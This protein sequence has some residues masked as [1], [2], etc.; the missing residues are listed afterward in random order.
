[1]DVMKDFGN[2]KIAASEG[3]T[4]PPIPPGRELISHVFPGDDTA[5]RTA[6]SRRRR[7]WATL[8]ALV[9]AGATA[10]YVFASEGSPDRRSA[11]VETP[12]TLKIQQGRK[13]PRETGSPTISSPRQWVEPPQD[14]APYSAKSLATAALAIEGADPFGGIRP[15]A[16]NVPVPYGAVDLTRL[17]ARGDHLLGLGDVASA[18]LVYRIAALGGSAAAAA[19]MGSTYDPKYLELAGAQG[20]EAKPAEAIKWYEK[21]FVM[22]EP[23]AE[24]RLRELLDSLESGRAIG[25]A[26][27]VPDY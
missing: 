27:I 5:Q 15:Q 24:A 16:R 20:I 7:R 3:P 4:D 26:T 12:A 17:V 25:T 14:I 23:A 18:R 13:D 22:G 19:A 11:R 1:M 9:G 10:F 21:A 2:Q 6:A 8:G